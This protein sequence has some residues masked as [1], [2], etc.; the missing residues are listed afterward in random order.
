M[1]KLR[2]YI[3]MWCINNYFESNDYCQKCVW[4][5]VYIW[6]SWWWDYGNDI[7]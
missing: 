3:F 2:N 5:F 1:Y 4:W 6:Q 7:L